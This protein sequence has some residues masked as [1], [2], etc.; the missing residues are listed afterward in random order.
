MGFF[1]VGHATIDIVFGER[2]AC[3]LNVFYH[4]VVELVCLVF[5]VE[6]EV[7]P[8]LVAIPAIVAKADGNNTIGEIVSAAGMEARGAVNVLAGAKSVRNYLPGH[9]SGS[10]GIADTREWEIEQVLNGALP[11]FDGCRSRRRFQSTH[12]ILCNSRHGQQKNTSVLTPCVLEF[13]QPQ[14]KQK[15]SGALRS[16]IVGENALLR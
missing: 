6:K 5:R 3:F 10:H 7:I 16:M 14:H 15:V 11:H 4:V 9:F 12:A 1:A 2:D 8:S 13:L